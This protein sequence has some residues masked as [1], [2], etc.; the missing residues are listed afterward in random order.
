MK[1]SEQINELATALSAAQGQIEDAAADAKGN[2]GKYADL[3]SIRKAIKDP[4]SKNGLAIFQIPETRDGKTVLVSRLMHKSGQ[5]IEG[6]CDLLVDKPTMQGM[7]SA[8]TYMKRYSLAAIVGI[9]EDDDDGQE[10]EKSPQKKTA[11]AKSG[12]SNPPVQPRA[13]GSPPAPN[14]A[15]EAQRKMIWARL[16]GELAMDEAQAKDF[17]HQ[18]TGLESSKDM[19]REQVQILVAEID[20]MAKN[21]QPEPGWDG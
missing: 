20:K 6:E 15:S 18:H 1:T 11:Q 10:A 3:T 21:E 17:I 7:G 16:R 2:F 8:I 5:W 19:N 9:A 12:A 14:L 13:P 4:L